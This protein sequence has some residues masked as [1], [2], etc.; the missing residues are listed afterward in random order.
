MTSTLH[1]PAVPFQAQGHPAAFSMKAFAAYIALT[2]LGLMVAPGALLAPLGIAAPAEIWV[3]VLGA[4][5]TVLAIYY[6]V[7]GASGNEAFIRATITGR[8]VFCAL[9]VGL[10]LLA[11]AP[12]QLLL[13]GAIDVVA[14]IW[15]WR[16]LR[17]AS[18]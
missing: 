16:A 6:W 7:G 2:G 11:S 9:C 4:V 13:F 3:R 10:I 15:T 12:P 18:R 1:P 8:I 14:A 5:A 17:P